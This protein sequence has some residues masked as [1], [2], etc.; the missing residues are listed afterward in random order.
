MKKLLPL[1]LLLSVGAH[2]LALAMLVILPAPA[3]LP[4]QSLSVSLL[5]GPEQLSQ[6]HEAGRAGAN[7]ESTRDLRTKQQVAR[8]QTDTGK[9]TQEQ[10]VE[11]NR[12]IAGASLPQLLAATPLNGRAL[13]TEIKKLLTANLVYPPIARKL[14]QQGRVIINVNLGGKG[15][16]EKTELV[17]SS[18]YRALDQAALRSIRDIGQAP[19]LIPWL[20]GQPASIRVPVIYRLAEA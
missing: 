15:Q 11:S 2:V 17:Q 9:S 3:P 10:V 4:G 7:G 20:N 12:A 13:L 5:A 6:T 8:M 14:G 1:F 19:Q 16:I 18:G